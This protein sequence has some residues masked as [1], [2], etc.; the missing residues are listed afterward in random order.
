MSSEKAFLR[1]GEQ[2]LQKFQHLRETVFAGASNSQIF[3]A[4]MAYGFGAGIMAKSTFPKSNNGPRTEISEQDFMLMKMLQLTQAK[5]SLSLDDSE[6]RYDM[7]MRFAETGIN[8][9][10]DRL[11][12]LTVTQAREEVLAILVEASEEQADLD[13]IEPGED[14]SPGT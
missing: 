2:S 6:A 4:A 10:W 1:F 5:D 3:F 13:A 11:G 8:L 12:T 14:E 7:A 9:L